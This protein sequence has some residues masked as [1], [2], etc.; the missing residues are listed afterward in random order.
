MLIT[1]THAHT[2]MPKKGK[3]LPLILEPGYS[4]LGIPVE[5]GLYRLYTAGPSDLLY[6]LLVRS[7][8]CTVDYKHPICTDL[9]HSDLILGGWELAPSKDMLYTYIFISP[10]QSLLL[11]CTGGKQTLADLR[12][13]PYGSIIYNG[14]YMTTARLKTFIYSMTYENE[15]NNL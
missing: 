13:G 1:L 3:Q 15:I 5:V 11:T 14:T 12:G 7:T 6:D 8:D 2:Y 4:C 9:T 10:S